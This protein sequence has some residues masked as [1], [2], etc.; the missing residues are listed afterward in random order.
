MPSFLALLGVA[1]SGGTSSM[2]SCAAKVVPC[3]APQA[4]LREGELAPDFVALGDDGST[5][6]LSRLR[7]RTVILHFYPAMEEQSAYDRTRPDADEG[8]V[9]VVGIARRP[10][11]LREHTRAGAGF[12]LVSDA[13]GAVASAYGWSEP[14]PD[15]GRRTFVIAPDGTIEKVLCTAK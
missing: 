15:D 8:G 11:L 10:D 7:S 3:I 9:V 2:Q 1:F 14:Y 12:V 13:D 6:S 5:V 4:R